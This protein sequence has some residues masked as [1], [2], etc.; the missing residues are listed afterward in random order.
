MS[1]FHH[2]HQN[3]TNHDPSSSCD[4]LKL[5]TER[6]D[7]FISRVRFLTRQNSGI[8]VGTLPKLSSFS[9]KERCEIVPIA[10]LLIR[11]L[12]VQ[13]CSQDERGVTTDRW[14]LWDYGWYKHG[15]ISHGRLLPPLLLLSSSPAPRHYFCFDTTTTT[16]N[17][18]PLFF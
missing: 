17:T 13:S 16:T 3:V 5:T 6:T 15:T 12:L 8:S 2:F 11:C 10:S 1:Y 9:R 14:E 7:S 18:P 4:N